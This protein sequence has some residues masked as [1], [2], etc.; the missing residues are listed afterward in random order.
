MPGRLVS[1]FD[2]GARPIVRGKARTPVE[3]G[4]KVLFGETDRGIISTYQVFEGNP[5]DTSLLRPGV[6][7]HRRLFHRRLKAVSGD[8]G[9]QSRENEEWLKKGGVSRVCL[10]HRGKADRERRQ[11]EREPW[12]RRL[13]RF[14]AG[15][16]GRVS[17]LQRK[18]GLGRSLMR[19]TPGTEIWVGL[20]VLAHNLW[21][22]AR[23][24]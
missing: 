3:F 22:T 12:F 14:R 18:F 21:Q 10:P 5:A 16:E 20:G 17:L 4:R 15:A 6:R 13:L 1:L 8:R 11:Q 7:G 9:F 19:G 2:P 24:A 23:R